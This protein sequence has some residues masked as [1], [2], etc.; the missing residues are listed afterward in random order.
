MCW[1]QINFISHIW[2]HFTLCGF[3][4]SGSTENPKKQSLPNSELKS[5]K[6]IGDQTR[7]KLP[8]CR[9]SVFSPQS[10]W[11][12]EQISITQPHSLHSCLGVLDYSA[13]RLEWGRHQYDGRDESKDQAGPSLGVVGLLSTCQG[14]KFTVHQ[15]AASSHPPAYIM[16]KKWIW[17]ILHVLQNGKECE[18]G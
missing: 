8:P 18:G 4:L 16:S 12:V 1:L 14:T 10:V 17:L 3:I 5:Q 15:L 13:R 11:N 9:C 6:R 7:V 2:P